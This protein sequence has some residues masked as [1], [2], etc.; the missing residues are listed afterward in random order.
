[1]SKWISGALLGLV[2]FGGVVY[3]LT[4]KTDP[5]HCGPCLIKRAE[6]APATSVC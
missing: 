1:M 6:T 3:V 2:T 4:A 5:S